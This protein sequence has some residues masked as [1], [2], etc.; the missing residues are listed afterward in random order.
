M[1]KQLKLKH[2][3]IENFILPSDV[4]K[5][6]ER[7]TW[8]EEEEKWILN[9]RTEDSGLQ[10]RSQRP[11]SALGTRSHQTRHAL[12]NA[13]RGNARY[14]CEN[15]ITIEL[16]M[17]SRTTVDY[18]PSC[19][20]GGLSMNYEQGYPQEYVGEYDPQYEQYDFNGYQE[21]FNSYDQQYNGQ[22]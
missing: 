2:G 13:N 12:I 5:M 18:D 6:E 16:E 22:Y 8:D 4:E 7:C 19:F 10:I 17:P 15:V 9:K 1:T 14:K 3:I 20:N 11:Q 21:G